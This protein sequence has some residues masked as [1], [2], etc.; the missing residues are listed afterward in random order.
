MRS[1]VEGQTAPSAPPPHFVRSPSP[2]AART[3]RNVHSKEAQLVRD[4]AKGTRRIYSI[5]PAGLGRRL[6]AAAG[7]LPGGGGGLG[8]V[9]FGCPVRSLKRNG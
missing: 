3:G 9:T 6:A 8:T 7:E 4:K 5:D 1:M 2:S